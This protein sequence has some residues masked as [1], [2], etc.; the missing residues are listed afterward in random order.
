MSYFDIYESRG[1]YRYPENTPIDGDEFSTPEDTT[2]NPSN[3]IFDIDLAEKIN[4]LEESESFEKKIDV[5]LDRSKIVAIANTVSGKTLG[6]IKSFGQEYEQRR[7]SEQVDDSYKGENSMLI[8]RSLSPTLVGPVPEDRIPQEGKDVAIGVEGSINNEGISDIEA[9]N[10]NGDSMAAAGSDVIVDNGAA[11]SDVVI[12]NGADK[13]VGDGKAES[14]F[15]T[16]IAVGAGLYL[17]YKV[18]FKK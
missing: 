18:V 7:D 14:H 17:L 2:S 11:G 10:G 9:K 12:D 8:S 16:Y 5:A 1:H 15:G 6:Q 13:S 4:K 3:P